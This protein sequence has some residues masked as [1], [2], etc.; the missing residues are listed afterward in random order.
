MEYHHQLPHVNEKSNRKKKIN[1]FFKKMFS[2][3]AALMLIC[4]GL[5]YFNQTRTDNREK[6]DSQAFTRFQYIYLG[7]Y[8]CM[9]FSD[10]LQGRCWCIICV[11][12]AADDS[13]SN[14][15][16]ISPLCFDLIFDIKEPMFMYCMN[17]M[18]TT[19]I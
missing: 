17:R 16:E 12:E 4:A 9:T 1:I 2:V 19:L 3:L 5:I 18:A 15:D 8:L 14:S 7:V 11:L 13:W 10:W 6:V